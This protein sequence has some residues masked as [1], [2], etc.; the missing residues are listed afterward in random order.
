KIRKMYKSL[1][2]TI[3]SYIHLEPPELEPV[4]KL[5]RVKTFR[6]GEYLLQE[7]QVSR[8]VGFI[9]QGVVRY[10][11][12]REG[13]EVTYNFGREG[14][15]VCNYVSFLQKD[16]SGK[17]IQAL[18]PSRIWMISSEDLQV[19]YQQVREGDKFGRL[20]IEKNYVEA[21]LQLASQYTDSA[22]ERYLKF[23]ASFP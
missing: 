8:H 1:I 11:Y 22:A 13:E 14:E 6:K 16:P 18:E 17:T 3:R 12:I 10:Y 21:I 20:L 9:E 19:F 15:F 4:Q 23:I 2:N 5:F 7:G